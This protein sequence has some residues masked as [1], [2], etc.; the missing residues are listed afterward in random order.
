M[1]IDGAD[2]QS[3]A[4]NGDRIGNPEES[5]TYGPDAPMVLDPGT[6]TLG[7]WLGADA[8]G[9]SSTTSCSTEIALQAAADIGLKAEFAPGNPCTW[10][11]PAA[12]TFPT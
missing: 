6:Y 7:A 5:V 4:L 12:P 2:L 1:S 3:G 9:K 11:A 10:D 8:V